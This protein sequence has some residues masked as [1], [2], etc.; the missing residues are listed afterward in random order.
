M[1]VTGTWLSR[2]P[3]AAALTLVA[4]CIVAFDAGRLLREPGERD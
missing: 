1:G 4:V 2:P 3:E